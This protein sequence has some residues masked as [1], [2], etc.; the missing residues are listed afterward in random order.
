[1]NDRTF[2]IRGRDIRKTFRRETGE[3]IVALDDVELDIRHGDLTALVGPDGAGKTTLIRLVAGLMAADGGTLEVLGIDVKGDPQAVQDRIGYMPQRFGLYEDLS[4]QE[5]LDLYADLHGVSAA[6]RRERYP[7]LMEMTALGPFTRRPA[8]RLSGGMKQKLG[9]ACTLVRVPDLL[10]LDEPT[11]GVD[12]LSRRE[13]WDIVRQLVDEGMSVLLST[14]YLDEAER[15]AH[16]VVLHEGKLMASGDP[17]EV[18]KRASGRSFVVTPPAG[19]PARLLQ[20]KLLDEPDIIDAV[21]QAGEVRI[22]RAA[23]ADGGEAESALAGLKVAR[24]E[25]R[26]EDGFMML[27]HEFDDGS[28]GAECFRG[29]RSFGCRGRWRHGRRGA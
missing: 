14:S 12:P 21:P 1:M 5:N 18:T 19:E 26:F 29:P 2:A 6:E 9:L 15:C 16:V 23:G 17:S 4:V 13:L 20:A 25:P 11:V 24:V 3:T 7:R 22:V 27:L 8:G 10:L 28:A